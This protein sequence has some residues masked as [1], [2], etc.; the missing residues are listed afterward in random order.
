MSPP[1]KSHKIKPCISAFAA[2]ERCPTFPARETSSEYRPISN[3]GC[4]RLD[5]PPALLKQSLATD[6]NRASSRGSLSSSLRLPATDLQN[7][8]ATHQETRFLVTY[9]KQTPAPQSDRYTFR[10][11]YFDFASP[12]LPHFRANFRAAALPLR[13][14]SALFPPRSHRRHAFSPISL[15]SPFNFLSPPSAFPSGMNALPSCKI[16]CLGRGI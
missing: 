7:L 3:R 9:R 11:A 12:S 4:R 13:S 6:S 8:I 16:N 10:D 15:S 5:F 2:N 14:H 1:R